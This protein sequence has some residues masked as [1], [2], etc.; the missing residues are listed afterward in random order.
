MK[1]K[2]I[3]ENWQQF[4][5]EQDKPQIKNI[6]QLK[7]VLQ[8]I[9]TKGSAEGGKEFIKDFGAGLLADLIPGGASIKTAFDAYKAVYSADDK[10]KTG[11]GLDYLN[12]DDKVS[13]I[14]D[15][16]IEMAFLKQLA[17]QIEKIK[18]PLTPIQNFDTDKLLAQ[19]IKDGGADLPPASDKTKPA[20]EDFAE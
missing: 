16:P 4:L 9:A 1:Y 17:K 18:D 6:G 19:F 7:K 2:Q 11:T 3:N 20:V 8:I 13:A 15:D 5:T 12:V 14:V 10:A